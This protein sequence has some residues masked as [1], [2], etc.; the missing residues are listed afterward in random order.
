MVPEVRRQ[1]ELARL[2]PVKVTPEKLALRV[3]IFVGPTAEVMFEGVAYSMPPEATHVAGTLFL[4][5]DRVH[6]VAGRFESQQRRRGKNE[7]HAPTPE[8][9]AAKIA[10]MPRVLPLRAPAARQRRR[11]RND[12]AP[13][14]GS[15]RLS[16]TAP[17]PAAV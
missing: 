13:S 8:H 5:E 3:P 17:V 10:A 4:Y 2:R 16:G 11:L 15:H 9:R 12:A 14:A 7:P 6:I 1:E